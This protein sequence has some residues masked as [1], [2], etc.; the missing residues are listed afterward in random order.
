MKAGQKLSW[1]W[2]LATQLSGKIR[3]TLCPLKLGSL[4]THLASLSSLCIWRWSSWF[5]GT[6]QQ[7]I[8][9]QKSMILAQLDPVFSLAHTYTHAYTR[10][11]LDLQRIYRLYPHKWTTWAP[12]YV[13]VLR[14]WLFI[15]RCITEHW[16]SQS[17]ALLCMCFCAHRKTAMC[18]QQKGFQHW[19]LLACLLH[20]KFYS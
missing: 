8:F 16:K 2:V 10:V 4:W 15:C 20:P 5:P 12:C 11:K 17:C 18:T 6:Q 19:L 13:D 1:G 9:S 14:F 7:H 3:Q